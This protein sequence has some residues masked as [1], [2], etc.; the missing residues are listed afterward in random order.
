M[1]W[2]TP[3]DKHD[4]RYMP[5]DIA[6][7]GIHLQTSP[8]RCTLADIA[9]YD[10]VYT[11]RQA[12]C[13]WYMTADTALYGIHLQ[14]STHCTVYA[15]RH[16]S[17]RYGIHLQTSAMYGT[18]PQTERCIAYTCRQALY[19]IRLQTKVCMIWYTPTDK[20]DVW[21]MPA[22]ITLYGIHLQTS[23]VRYTLADIALYD[24]VYAC[25][26]SFV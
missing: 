18:C 15:C 19:G 11:N 23:T 3:T 8:V 6:L 20:R 12:R 24:R 22:D 26:H 7:Y 9:L 2:Y 5:G 25:G 17:V 1:I 21:Y 10:M 4:V 14:T 13:I 16:S